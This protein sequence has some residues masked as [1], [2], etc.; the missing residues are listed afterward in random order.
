M[1]NNFAIMKYNGKDLL[2]LTFKKIIFFI[3]Y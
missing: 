2:S 1:L 3:V